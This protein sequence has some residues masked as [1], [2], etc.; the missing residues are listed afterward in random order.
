MSD[1]VYPYPA[2]AILAR[3]QAEEEK[4]ILEERL[5]LEN[6]GKKRKKIQDECKNRQ[7]YA[8]KQE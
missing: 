7:D 3:F 6:A 1:T 2:L 5:G 4:R 8:A